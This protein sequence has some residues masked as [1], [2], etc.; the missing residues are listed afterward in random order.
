MNFVWEIVYYMYIMYVGTLVVHML[1]FIT[2]V[3]SLL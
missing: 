3:A 1:F 2:R